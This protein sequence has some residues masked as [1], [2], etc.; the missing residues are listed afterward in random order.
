MERPFKKEDFTVTLAKNGIV[1]N[2]RQLQQFDCY[3]NMLID[4]NTRMN[5]TAITDPEGIYQKHF[6]D[7]LIPSFHIE[8]QGSLCDIGAGAGFPSIPLKIVYPELDVT[9][10]EPLGKRITFLKA[11]CEALEINVTLRNER[12]EDAVKNCREAFDIVTARAVA[13]LTMLA[14]LCIPFV[15]KD[16]IFLA[17]KGAKGKEELQDASYAIKKLGC[18]VEAMYEETLADAIRMDFVLRKVKNTPRCYPRAFAKIKKHPLQEGI[19]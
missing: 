4:W 2:E 16:G 7:S 14:E 1:L 9:I 11:L 10:V 18:V 12:G 15:K 8:M 3:M 13:N 6:L 19:E 17:M 5:L